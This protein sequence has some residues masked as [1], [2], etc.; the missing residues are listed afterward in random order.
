MLIIQ[1]C[2][3]QCVDYVLKIYHKKGTVL[4]IVLLVP[5]ENTTI[6]DFCIDHECI[7]LNFYSQFYPVVRRLSQTGTQTHEKKNGENLHELSYVAS[8]R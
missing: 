4:E 7:Q 8:L 1:R 2:D 5:C 3:Q 6:V